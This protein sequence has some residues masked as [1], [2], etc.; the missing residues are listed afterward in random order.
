MIN[1]RSLA[2]HSGLAKVAARELPKL[3]MLGRPVVSGDIDGYQVAANELWAIQYFK[4][5][6]C[7]SK[8]PKS[9]NDVEHYRP[10]AR[11][12]RYPGCGTTHGY[13]WLAFSLYNLLFACP[14]CNRSSKNDRFPLD[15][16]GVTMF[17]EQTPPGGELPLLIDPGGAENPVKHMMFVAFPRGSNGAGERFSAEDVARQRWIAVP[18][19]GSKLGQSTIEIA[20]LNRMELVEM[21]SDYVRQ[22][23]WPLADE[24]C[25][26]LVEGVNWKID[27]RMCRARKLVSRELPFTA[28]A[29]DALHA[30]VPPKLL[31]S[32]GLAW[33]ELDEVG[34]T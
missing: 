25:S 28:L 18:R 3:R 7:E 8:I 6:Y 12:N 13:W 27:D 9:Y 19:A 5:C 24:L 20:D 16:G 17:A 34:K 2:A 32:A 30:L 23:V 14:S 26:A 22:T 10:K 21:R 4:C 1:V 31:S 15:N 29:F 33:C 11:A